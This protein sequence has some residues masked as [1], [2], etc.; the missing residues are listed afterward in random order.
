MK[1]RSFLLSP[2]LV[3]SITALFLFFCLVLPAQE[4]QAF[5]KDTHHVVVTLAYD[6]LDRVA[7]GDLPAPDA[8]TSEEASETLKW[9]DNHPINADVDFGSVEYAKGDAWALLG[10]KPSDELGGS[11]AL[12]GEAVAPDRNGPAL[13][14][15]PEPVLPNEVFLSYGTA[16]VDEFTDTWIGVAKFFE[17]VEEKAGEQLNSKL[18]ELP[19]S[20]A[21]STYDAFDEVC[22]DLDD[23]PVIGWFV[24]AVCRIIAAVAAIVVA[25]IGL[26]VAAVA[27]LIT[28]LTDTDEH[29]A[30]EVLMGCD[31]SGLVDFLE[32][33]GGDEI[34]DHDEEVWAG[35]PDEDCQEMEEWLEDIDS[36][37]FWYTPEDDDSVAKAIRIR[38]RQLWDH[39]KAQDLTIEDGVIDDSECHEAMNTFLGTWQHSV[40]VGNEDYWADV[41]YTEITSMNHFMDLYS[42]AGDGLPDYSDPIAVAEDINDGLVLGLDNDIDGY[43]LGDGVLF[44][45]EVLTLVPAFIDQNSEYQQAYMTWIHGTAP[46]DGAITSAAIDFGATISWPETGNTLL[47]RQVNCGVLSTHD[48]MLGTV[49][50]NTD[51]SEDYTNRTIALVI[52]PPSDNASLDG[53]SMMLDGRIPFMSDETGFLPFTELGG[54]Y[55]DR[56]EPS[57]D[58]DCDEATANALPELFLDEGVFPSIGIYGLSIPLHMIQDLA[59]P[60][61]LAPTTGFGHRAFESWV[62]D[63]LKGQ[64]PVFV[65]D[66]DVDETNAVIRVTNLQPQAS[67]AGANPAIQAWDFESGLEEPLW[68]E[69]PGAIDRINEVMRVLANGTECFGIRRLLTATALVTSS[70]VQGEEASVLEAQIFVDGVVVEAFPDMVE[71]AAGVSDPA[72]PRSFRDYAD[73]ALPHATAATALVL[74]NAWRVSNDVVP[75]CDEGWDNDEIGTIE[76]GLSIAWDNTDCIAERQKYYIEE[77]DLNAMEALAKA[78]CECDEEDGDEREDEEC[79]ALELDYWSLVTLSTTNTIDGRT[80]AYLL[81]RQAEERNGPADSNLGMEDSDGDGIPDPADN[82]P[83]ENNGW[84]YEPGKGLID[85]QVSLL[86]D[87]GSYGCASD[88]DGDGVLD[89]VDLCPDSIDPGLVDSRG[90]SDADY[91][92]VMEAVR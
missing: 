52:H 5:S 86:D 43:S 69:L 20:W 22:D 76:G 34:S 75:S 21:D 65:F 51:G 59:V 92:A 25:I 81:E 6:Y 33:A 73:L 47:R 27:W 24:G 8:F 68:N 82:C 83:H 64:D 71:A 80:L 48:G 44:E 14:Y 78:R 56:C 36:L 39:C 89:A 46:T 10:V 91:N 45:G 85:P 12:L 3:N 50:E 35:V 28:S 7:E 79:A 32:W 13:A 41:S 87:P 61:H 2:L 11:D 30:E 19:G 42:P 9:L 16:H 18:A 53:W 54:A 90:C 31:P 77:E 88:E 84:K 29:L 38:M 26:G 17:A 66:V 67:F 40:M 55:I 60:M 37:R 70:L 72:G 74:V 58:L 15:R 57:A 49:C 1:R 63:Y 4:A 62:N 23:I